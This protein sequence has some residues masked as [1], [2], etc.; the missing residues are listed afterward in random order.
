MPSPGVQCGVTSWQWVH[1]SLRAPPASVPLGPSPS[2]SVCVRARVCVCSSNALC[3]FNVLHLYP[4]RFVGTL[5]D[6]PVRIRPEQS[7]G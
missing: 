4:H 6:N 3:M 7:T 5:R 2:L 1:G